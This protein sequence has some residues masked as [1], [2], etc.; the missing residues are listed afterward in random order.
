[1][2]MCFCRTWFTAYECFEAFF[3]TRMF[4][5]RRHN[6]QR[7]PRKDGVFESHTSEL[8][9]WKSF[10]NPC[11]Y[12]KRA[13]Y[14]FES[15]VSEKELTEPHWVL[16]QARW[17]LRK[18]RWVRFGTQ[19]IGWEELTEFAPRNSVSPEKLTELGVWK[20][21]LRNRIRPVSDLKTENW[22]KKKRT[23][24]FF[25]TTRTWIY[26]NH[27]FSLFFCGVWDGFAKRIFSLFLCGGGM[28][29][30]KGSSPHFLCVCVRVGDGLG[31]FLLFPCIWY[32]SLN[33]SD[34][35]MAA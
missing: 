10:R 20:R 16:R 18:T 31:S 32:G 33:P 14:C 15:T 9:F 22:K 17:V 11:P 24:S 30:L 5:T 27:L 34:S 23:R 2:F 8:K 25:S 13:E 19:I 35:T 21:T 26:Y 4:K 7:S 3:G 6:A 1:M 29:L 12:R 28:D